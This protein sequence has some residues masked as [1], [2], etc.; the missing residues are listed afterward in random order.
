M[1]AWQYD[2][3]HRTLDLHFTVDGHPVHAW[4]TPRP[5]YCDRGHWQFNVNGPF[6]LDGAD[7]FPRY[8]MHLDDAIREAEAWMRWRIAKQTQTPNFP[9]LLPVFDGR[10]FEP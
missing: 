7:S 4:I 6:D 5:L 9:T 3:Q 8:F 2:A 10:V 1:T